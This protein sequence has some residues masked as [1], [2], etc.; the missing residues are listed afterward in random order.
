M[1]GVL[2]VPAVAEGPHDKAIKARKA[3]MTLFSWNL[4][5][6]GAMAKEVI[7]Y[8]A[9]AA[10]KAADNLVAVASLNGENMWPA[11]SDSTALPGQT[12]AKKEAWDTYPEV[13]GK[14][15]DLVKAATELAA[16]AGDGLDALKAAVGATGKTCGGCHKPFREEE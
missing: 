8:D 1:A 9:E 10:Q 12:R 6:L 3:Q 11:G 14:H 2:A 7:P 5:Q 4:G 13:A 15:E 16:S